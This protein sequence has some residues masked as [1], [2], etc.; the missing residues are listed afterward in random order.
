MKYDVFFSICQTP[1]DGYQP[2]ERVMLQNFFDQAF[3]ADE[4]GYDCA[5]VAETHLSCQVQ[6]KNP[7]AV[8]P[9]FEGEIGLNTDIL[10]IAHILFA[11]TKRIHVGSA[12]RNI[13]CN[14]GPIAHAEAIKMFLS[15]HGLGLNRAAGS[16][17]DRRLEVGFASGR[18][19]FSNVPYGIYPRNELERVA[20]PALR[21]LI[22]Q[23]ATEV[24]LRLLK[25]EIIGSQDVRPKVLT[26]ARF[27]S[28]DDWAR[29]QVAAKAMNQ[30]S[31]DR[32]EIP[33]FWTFDPVGV[34]PFEAPMQNLRLT[35]GAHDAETQDFAN[36]I[37]PVGVFNLSITPS[38]QIEATHKRMLTTYGR[39][40]SGFGGMPK[41]WSR[42]LMPRTVLV[43]VDKDRAKAK[44]A[45]EKA[46]ANYWKAVEG[47]LD[48]AKIAQAV[49]NAIVGEPREVVE[50]MNQRFNVDDRL[51]LWFDFNN[52]D[53]ESVKS[54]MRLFME[55]C[56]PHVTGCEGT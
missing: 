8:I 27:R 48:P 45:A 4:L 1:V 37:L 41:E 49:D 15:L 34:I 6:K 9:H 21:G 3:L 43:F 33:S 20:W 19:P 40:A 32:I 7:G 5:W 25:G 50:Q 35:I 2:S 31:A 51:M 24:F 36:T 42:G 55:E 13:Q 26:R 46:I 28:D 17:E 53:N 12:I 39:G 14:G 29:V 18:F 52:H 23:E 22:F 16:A 56:A 38:E 44:L 54:S 10:Q 30:A 47:T 11:K